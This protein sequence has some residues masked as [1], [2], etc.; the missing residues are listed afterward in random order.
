MRKRKALSFLIVILIG[1]VLGAIY[2]A[3]FYYEKPEHAVTEAMDSV[4]ARNVE[5]AEKYLDYRNMYGGENEEDIYRA[6]MRDFSYE[7]NN[8]TQ[9]GAE[10][11]A[12]LTVSNRDME[13]I[14]GQFVVDAYQLV[15]SDAYQPEDERMGEAELK[16]QIDDMLLEA[17]TESQTGARS[18]TINVDMIRKGRSWYLNFDHDDLDAVYGGYLSA[19]EA[20]DNVLGDRST[21]ALSNLE[22]AYRRNIDDAKHVLRNAVHY[23]VDDVWNSLLCHIISCINAGTDINGDEY[24]IVNG[25]E[26]L[27]ELLEEREQYDTYIAALDDVN[28]A[29]IKEGWKNLTDACD[30]L[31]TELDEEQ[32]EP[33]DFDY[34]PDTEEFQEAMHSFVRLIYPEE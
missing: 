2:F 20:A 32:P 12:D 34:I 27:H 24:D 26:E 29:K 15:I 31:V 23:M 14:Y 33:L 28:Y 6:I 19:Q 30:A 25:M 7:V 9:V 8:V 11:V 10:A 13:A 21:E 17:L 1:M 4:I 18:E 3:N 5:T 22:K 16:T